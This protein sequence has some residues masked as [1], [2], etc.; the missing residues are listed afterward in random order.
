MTEPSS[1]NR[2]KAD[3]SDGQEPSREQLLADALAEFLDRDARE[4]PIPIEEFCRQH[5]GVA[6]E[7]QAELQAL[8]EIEQTLTPAAPGVSAGVQDESLP[9]RLSGYKIL[10]NIGE[11]GMGR[12]LLAL[13]ERLGRKVA[14]KTLSGRYQNDAILR[15]RF[16]QEARAL[17]QINHSN[18]VRIYN[19]G[20]P[21]E[22]P[23]FVMEYVTGVPLTEASRALTIEQRIELMRKVVEAAEFLHQNHVIHRDLKPG[24]ILVGADLEP[25]LLDF[26]LARH[27]GEKASRLTQAGDVMGTPDY[28]SPEQ[29]QGDLSLD[30]RSDI[31]SLGT[32]LYELL[33]G[34]VP[35]QADRRQ[36][37]VRQICEGDPVLPRRIDRSI[38]G[39]LQNICLKA[40][41]KR[42]ADRYG[43][44]REMARDLERFLAG[45]TVLAN[46]TSYS[47]IMSGKIE[48]HVKELSGWQ[49]DRILS[50][51]ELDAFRKL[52]DRLVDREDA[53]ILE[54]RRLSLSQVSL[55][56]GAWIL[57]VAAGLVLLFRYPGLAGT[58]SVLVV[59]AAT[60]PM[61]WIGIR[62]WKQG[63]RRI[64]VAFLLAFCLLLPTATLVAMKEWKILAHFSQ[65]K[66]SLEFFAKFEMFRVQ[67][68]DT[69][70]APVAGKQV[71]KV[72]LFKGTTNAQLWWALLLSLPAYFWLRRFTGAS[73]F[74]L[75]F[76]VMSA[77]LCIVTLLR[78]GMLEWLDLDPG[79]VY[80]RLIPFAILFFVLAAWVEQIPRPN[81]SRYFYPIAVLY[82]FIALSGVAYFHEPYARWLD[83]V[84]P[85]TR[86]QVEYLFIINAGIYLALQSVS[87]RFGSPQMRTV[88]K[89]FRFVIPGH[90]L[91]S[92]LLLGM[93]ASSRWEDALDRVDLRHE[94]RFFEI[95][96]PVVACL[97]VL[98]SV[99]KQMKNFF[100]TGLLFLAVGIARLQLD[101]FKE[102]PVWPIS[103]L[104]AGLLLMLL[105]ANTT[106][107]KLALSRWLRR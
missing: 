87:E 53:W 57:V 7:L 25:K 41:E 77:L 39:D 23:H 85:R 15:T 56:L 105:A 99:P 12:V 84:V 35:F 33:T 107:V 5:P 28:F 89:S 14:I 95:L 31:F 47:R 96:L 43:S 22:V 66:E 58:P 92:L 6:H 73:V 27:A 82:S 72:S 98:G 69:A 11:G 17:A 1:T 36:D 51:Y 37:L 74:S 29:A 94:A 32:V 46:P 88:A 10:G 100:V 44:A 18:I 80:F 19:L 90:V 97:F 54:V 104:I 26:G 50:L 16:M 86:G 2:N 62:A 45:E 24:N 48:Q 93:A 59:A 8:L 71:H 70:P 30:A 106:R 65:G 79:R 91:T 83:S 20:Q 81:D 101:L 60:A 75:V 64:A 78:M 55:Y 76:S 21:E 40:M 34:T 9:E 68:A 103:L 61:A 38:P 49:Q 52:Y 4:Q 63:Q 67:P 42:P 13:D 102:R 3:E